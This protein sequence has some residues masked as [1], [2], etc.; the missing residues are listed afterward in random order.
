MKELQYKIYQSWTNISNL[1]DDFLN[2]EP[3]LAKVRTPLEANYLEERSNVARSINKYIIRLLSP[4]SRLD[5]YSAH[6][7]LHNLVTWKLSFS[8]YNF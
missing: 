7:I 6:W 8:N 5:Y 3:A 4:D 2:V 1:I